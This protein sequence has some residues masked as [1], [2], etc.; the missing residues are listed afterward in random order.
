MKIEIWSD[1][2]CPWCYVAKATLEQALNE[3]NIQAEYIYHSYQTLP[4]G[5][6]PKG[7]SFSIYEIANKSGMDNN[8][9][10]Q[11]AELIETMGKEAGISLNMND[12]KMTDTTNAHRLLK[13]AHQFNLQ[14]AFMMASYRMVFTEGGDLS[15]KEQLITLAVSVGMPKIEIVSLLDSDLYT[16]DV[17]SDI[18]TTRRK[19]ISGVPYFLF[20][21]NQ[22]LYGAQ[23]IEA[24]RN[25]LAKIDY[26]KQAYG[27]CGLEGQC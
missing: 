8:Q 3:S 24:F 26:P 23:P 5:Y 1:F 9:A 6:Y 19:R 27:M 13:L 7:M 2:T 10:V 17:I 18:H 15:N 22:C 16:Q 20:S 4:Q 25:V 11:K 12:V 14:D 21:G